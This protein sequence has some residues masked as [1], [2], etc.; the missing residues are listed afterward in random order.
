MQFTIAIFIYNNISNMDNFLQEGIL[1]CD[2]EMDIVKQE[3]S[4]YLL[5]IWV[6][7]SFNNKSDWYPLHIKSLS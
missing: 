7:G 3:K 2:Y 5:N 6:V 4:L 1:S